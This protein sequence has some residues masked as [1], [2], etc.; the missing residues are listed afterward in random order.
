[1]NEFIA[2]IGS[3]VMGKEFIKGD[4]LRGGGH[5]NGWGRLQSSIVSN[6]VRLDCLQ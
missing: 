5:G 3:I 2:G 1:L 4:S 6:L